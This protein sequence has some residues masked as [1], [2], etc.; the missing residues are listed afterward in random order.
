META[1]KQER[2]LRGWTQSEA[3][4]KMGITKAAYANIETGIRKPSYDTLIKLLDLFEYEDPRK[5]LG[6]AA[7]AASDMSGGN[8]ANQKNTQV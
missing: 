1:L 3:A 7:P 8:R 4:E 5:L 6:A 2:I